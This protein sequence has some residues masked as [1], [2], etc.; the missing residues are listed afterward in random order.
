MTEQQ[1]KYDL[2]L[3][4]PRQFLPI[5]TPLVRY[6]SEV[7]LTQVVLTSTPYMAWQRPDHPEWTWYYSMYPQISVNPITRYTNSEWH[8]TY[9]HLAVSQTDTIVSIPTHD[10]KRIVD[11]NDCEL[12][13]L[14][15]TEMTSDIYNSR[16]FKLTKLPKQLDSV[17]V[18]FAR[19]GDMLQF[20]DWNEPRTDQG[21]WRTYNSTAEAV[22]LFNYQNSR[23]GK[24]V[25]VSSLGNGGA[26]I[27]VN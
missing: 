7:E 8:K 24:R 3:G 6:L 2:Y 18:E 20:R 14:C 12:P 15:M 16:K 11:I 13:Y 10:D 4:F 21:T 5:P 25:I 9:D 26:L 27:L 19:L 17:V 22:T 23:T 1:V